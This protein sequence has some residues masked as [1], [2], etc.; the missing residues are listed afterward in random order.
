MSR[1]RNAFALMVLLATVSAVG[2][3]QNITVEH[4]L[5]TAIVPAGPQRGRLRLR[6]PRHHGCW[7]SNP[8]VCP[9]AA[10]SPRI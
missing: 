5:G 4:E 9:R 10:R 7:A 3:A 1:M 2:L 8:S 6:R